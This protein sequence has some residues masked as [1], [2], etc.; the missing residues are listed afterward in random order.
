[1]KEG[2]LIRIRHDAESLGDVWA[3]RLNDDPRNVLTPNDGNPVNKLYTVSSGDLF[4]YYNPNKIE[5][6]TGGFFIL[7]LEIEEDDAD[8]EPLIGD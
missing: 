3:V 4:R 2:D 5:H 8:L 1:M 7:D 6:L